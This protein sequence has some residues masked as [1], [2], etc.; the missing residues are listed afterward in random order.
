MGKLSLQ[1]VKPPGH[2]PPEEAELGFDP[3]GLLKG[4]HL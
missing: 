3:S 2:G 1:E 4:P